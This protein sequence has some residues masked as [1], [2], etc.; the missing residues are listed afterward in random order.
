MMENRT[1]E[2]VDYDM[3]KCIHVIDRWMLAQV[4]KISMGDIFVNSIHLEKKS[5]G[6]IYYYPYKWSL[7][8]YYSE[9]EKK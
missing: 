9:Y 2:Y 8:I 1:Y 7:I 5:T 3:N 6:D 4:V